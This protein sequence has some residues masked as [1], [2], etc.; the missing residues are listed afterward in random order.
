MGNLYGVLNTMDLGLAPWMS[1]KWKPREETGWRFIEDP[2]WQEE[3]VVCGNVMW[4]L[5]RGPMCHTCRLDE[6]A[7]DYKEWCHRDTIV[8]QQWETDQEDGFK[9]RPKSYRMRTER[10]NK[11]W[12]ASKAGKQWARHSA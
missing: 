8:F 1:S 10:T 7:A 11:S 4:T 5:S 2:R 6:Y 3:C 12:K 9:A